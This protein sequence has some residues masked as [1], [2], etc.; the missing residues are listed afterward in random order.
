[1]EFVQSL[2]LNIIVKPPDNYSVTHKLLDN[3]NNGTC[4]DCYQFVIKRL[5]EMLETCINTDFFKQFVLFPLAELN[6][7]L[8]FFV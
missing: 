1:M 3:K 8:N 6:P 2:A 7:F 4:Y 5:L